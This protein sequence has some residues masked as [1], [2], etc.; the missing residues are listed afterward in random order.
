MGRQQGWTMFMPTWVVIFCCS[1]LMAASLSSS[2]LEIHAAFSPGAAAGDGTLQKLFG[3]ARGCH[4][5]RP[6]AMKP[7]A[8]SRLAR[9]AVGLPLG[10]TGDNAS[11]PEAKVCRT[12]TV[13]GGDTTYCLPRQPP[14]V[15]AEERRPPLPMPSPGI[16]AA[17]SVAT[18]DKCTSCVSGQS[19]LDSSRVTGGAC[20]SHFG[21]RVD[22]LSGLQ[23]RARVG[24]SHAKRRPC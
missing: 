9:A 4:G 19:A 18:V 21:M 6:N 22:G 23:I 13:L 3:A 20:P 15:K 16:H 11:C 2:T 12:S 5:A 14:S 17:S 8:A 24:K 1:T 7:M 10:C